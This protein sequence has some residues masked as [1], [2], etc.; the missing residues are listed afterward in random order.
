MP[1]VICGSIPVKSWLVALPSVE[2]ARPACCVWCRAPSRP[3]GMPL[4]VWGHGTRERQLCGPLEPGG[5]AERV[6]VVV[7][8]YLCRVCGRAMTVLPRFATERCWYP[9]WVV[10]A[11]LATWVCGDSPSQ[12]RARLS[13]DT[14]WET[15]WPS[16]RRWAAT[17]GFPEGCGYEGKPLARA[18]AL[19]QAFSGCAPPDFHSESV[20]ERAVA[21]ARWVMARDARAPPPNPPPCRIGAG[22][23][24]S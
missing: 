9:L 4:G 12:V 5:A 16:V 20:V 14:T 7:R 6:L 15:G 2:E 10:V 19:V 23:R 13:P 1:V 24:D 17:T 11:A 21:G 18:A 22:F 8:R 3:I